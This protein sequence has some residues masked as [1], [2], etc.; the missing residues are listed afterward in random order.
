MTLRHMKIFTTVCRYQS[1]T[2]AAK[3]L[4]MAQ[5][6]VSLAI[7][8]LEEH[9]GTLL[10]ERFNK[11]LTIT[12][13]GEKLQIYAVNILSQLEEAETVIRDLDT[14]GLL[15]IGGNITVGATILPKILHLW[16]DRHPNALAQT[17]IDRSSYLEERLLNNELDFALMDTKVHSPYL[18]SEPFLEDTLLLL[19]N[20]E[21]PFAKEKEITIQDLLKEPLLV[22]EKGSGTRDLVDRT[23][24]MFGYSLHPVMES[25]STKALIHS[26]SYNLGI[27]IVSK[28]L[29]NQY[30][31]SNAICQLTLKNI[32]LNRSFSM[33][34]HKNK[35]MTHLIS[36]FRKFLFE[37]SHLL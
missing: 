16:S 36:D 7:K 28:Q 3:T 10:F 22:R 24:E 14:K 5:P 4:Y 6:A 34:Y 23:L 21:H 13:A 15:R 9:Y 20:E 11:R 19:C 12:Q 2:K 1:I 25:T 27:A 32:P 18:K 37:Y 33:V 31:T 35:Y 17:I 26:V 29:A 8:E 30:V